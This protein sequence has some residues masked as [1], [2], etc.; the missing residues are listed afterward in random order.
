[1]ASQ[2]LKKIPIVPPNF[3]E[4]R[5]LIEKVLSYSDVQRNLEKLLRH[6]EFTNEY[7]SEKYTD[8]NRL[9]IAQFLI[10]REKFQLKDRKTEEQRIKWFNWIMNILKEEKI[11]YAQSKRLAKRQGL[12]DA[13]TRDPKQKTISDTPCHY[14]FIILNTTRKII[15]NLGLLGKIEGEYFE[16]MKDLA[17]LEAKVQSCEIKLGYKGAKSENFSFET[18]D[19]H[20]RLLKPKLMGLDS[21]FGIVINQDFLNFF[22]TNE[23]EDK[24]AKTQELIVLVTLFRDKEENMYEIRDETEQAD[25]PMP[26]LSGGISEIEYDGNELKELAES[27]RGMFQQPEE[28][29]V[30]TSDFLNSPTEGPGS[31]PGGPESEPE[32]PES[33]PE[34]SGSTLG[35][36]TE[37]LEGDNGPG[38][39]TGPGGGTIPNYTQVNKTRLRNPGFWGPEDQIFAG[40][41]Y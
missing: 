20:L 37:G 30:S 2:G 24:E 7:F 11:K 39:D 15:T 16:L 4:L 6:P 36:T 8:K 12:P 31:T 25:L 10:L 33:G 23:G 34:G 18:L 5:D 32:G 1:M 14:Y 3:V 17:E 41:N 19:N 22:D 40:G 21:S 35:S 26:E 9:W 29:S 27:E 28:G 38:G 13:P